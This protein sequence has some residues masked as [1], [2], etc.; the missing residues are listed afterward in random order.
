MTDPLSHQ[1]PHRPRLSPTPAGA[2]ER[3]SLGEATSLRPCRLPGLPALL[4][5]LR[6][7]NSCWSLRPQNPRGD[8]TMEVHGASLGERGGGG[9]MDKAQVR[10]QASG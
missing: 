9:R 1:H 5:G 4:L 2:P 10:E 6:R 3:L 8:A 7:E